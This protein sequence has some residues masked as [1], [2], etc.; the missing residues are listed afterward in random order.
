[1]LTTSMTTVTSTKV[2]NMASEAVV[3]KELQKIGVAVEDVSPQTLVKCDDAEIQ[4]HSVT[5]S[6]LELAR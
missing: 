3:R 2:E 4:R 5:C 1:M 6:H